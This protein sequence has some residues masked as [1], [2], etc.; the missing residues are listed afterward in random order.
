M[1]NNN[2]NPMIWLARLCY[3]ENHFIGIS[4]CQETR[5]WIL[6]NLSMFCVWRLCSAGPIATV[7]K[8][9]RPRLKNVSVSMSCALFTDPQTFFLANF[10]LKIDPT[11]LFIHLKLFCYSFFNNKWYPNRPLASK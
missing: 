2:N 11:V 7:A 3:F 6:L 5:V 4:N 10:L 8:I 9:P 1:N